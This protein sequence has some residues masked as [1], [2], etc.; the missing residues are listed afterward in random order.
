MQHNS[1]EQQVLISIRQIIRATDIY[2]RKL[3]KEVG[4]TAPQLLI[5]QAI[6]ELGAVSISKLS[7]N[8]SLSQAT[9]TNIIDRL[10][11]RSLVD[12]HR[13]T[14]DKRVVHATLTDA[15]LHKVSEAPTPIQNTLSLIHI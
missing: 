9:V 3:S 13:S 6:K 8:V 4:L 12:R 7:E 15:G 5:L 11:S 14:Q 1:Q 2:S 10:E